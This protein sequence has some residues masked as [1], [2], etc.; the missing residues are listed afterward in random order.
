MTLACCVSTKLFTHCRFS[1]A[2]PRRSGNV[3][4]LCGE[5]PEL[6]E[7][8]LHS[9]AQHFNAD[10]PCVRLLTVPSFEQ[11]AVQIARVRGGRWSDRQHHLTN[12]CFTAFSE[13][14]AS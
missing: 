13:L 9:L 7:L 12:S 1:G 5:G 8:V 6:R 3:H 14:G 4:A 10:S 2:E 11:L